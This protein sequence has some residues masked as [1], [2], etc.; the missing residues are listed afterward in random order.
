MLDRFSESYL[1]DWFN[2]P[3]RKPLVLRGARQVGKSTMVREFARRNNKALVEI[4]LEWHL[5]LDNIF[6]TLDPVIAIREIEALTGGT[7]PAE[8]Y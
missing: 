3:T 7:F 8:I 6:K 2:K 5:F 1:R 4:N